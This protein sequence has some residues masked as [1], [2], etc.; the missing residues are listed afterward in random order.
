MTESAG[1]C[2]AGG[3]DL[4]GADLGDAAVELAIAG[5]A[6][7]WHGRA[8][9]PEEL[10]PARRHLAM[11]TARD[12]ARL[13]RA[14][15]DGDGRLVGVHGLTLRRT[16][17]SFEHDG[18]VHHTWCAFDSVG[19]PAALGLDA[20]A[21]TDCPT[22]VAPIV[23]EVRGGR[24]DGDGEVLWLPTPQATSHLMNEFCASAD[25]YCTIEHLEERVGVDS[26]S[27]RA[28]TLADA[29]ALG[30]ETW[31]DVVGLNLTDGSGD[32]P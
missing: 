17:H 18:R 11:Q 15:L 24:V 26:G 4:L 13:G 16:R 3:R 23:V 9:D 32:E 29:A 20:T 25:L 31:S 22:C 5:F 27:G 1:C 7:L 21:A 12:L 30:A 14:E 6:A 8:R 28:V 10:L 2:G 19:I